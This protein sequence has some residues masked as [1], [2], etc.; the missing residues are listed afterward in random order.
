MIGDALLHDE[1][2]IDAVEAPGVLPEAIRLVD[3]FAFRHRTE[4]LNQVNLHA[5]E[6]TPWYASYYD[7]EDLHF[8]ER[9]LLI[10]ERKT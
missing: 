8:L 6:E 9:T 7:P 10:G 5:T 3:H 1:D 4:N 2:G